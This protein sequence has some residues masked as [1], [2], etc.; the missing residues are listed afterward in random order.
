VEDLRTYA[1]AL[2]GRKQPCAVRASNA[3]HLLLTGIVSA[4][5]AAH[6][7]ET[8]MSE[9]FFSGWGIRTLATTE[10]RYGPITYHNG[11]I[12]PHDN[13]LIALGLGEYGYKSDVHRVMASFLE[14]SAWL[15][16]HRLPELYSGFPRRPGQGPIEYP[17]ACA[18]QAWAAGAPFLML[19]ACLGLSVDASRKQVV[20][21]RPSLPEY[22]REIRID[23]IRAGDG[24]VDLV[25]SYHQAD[26]VSVNVA[27]RTG[28]VE[29]VVV[30]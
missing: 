24:S 4:E 5:R 28:G 25:V 22:L 10:P 6:V 19:R 2:D 3:G 14:A 8:L 12:W 30:K 16:F 7:A 13:A 17:L 29:V 26:D 27:G 11:S 15:E 23:G 20:L 1:L 21:K 18:P 9:T